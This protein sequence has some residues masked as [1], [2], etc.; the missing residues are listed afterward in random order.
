M[1]FV[2]ITS[3]LFSFFRIAN[4]EDRCGT[5]EHAHRRRHQVVADLVRALFDSCGVELPEAFSTKEGSLSFVDSALH[6]TSWEDD[7]RNPVRDK[8][9]AKTMVESSSRKL[10]SQQVYKKSKDQETTKLAQEALIHLRIS[11]LDCRSKDRKDQL[12]KIKRAVK[13]DLEA[14]INEK[15][16]RTT[17]MALYYEYVNKDT[18]D[19]MVRNGE[20]RNRETGELIPPDDKDWG[21]DNS[22]QPGETSNRLESTD[23]DDTP[24]EEQR[25]RL[26]ADDR[27]QRMPGRV[28]RAKTP[29]RLP[30]KRPSPPR[31]LGNSFSSAS[32]PLSHGDFMSPR[33]N[34]SKQGS[35]RQTKEQGKGKGKGKEKAK[36]VVDEDG[37]KT[38]TYSKG[39][40]R[41]RSA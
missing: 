11:D 20:I 23:E 31:S 7:I 21:W 15:D 13:E 5:L 39:T 33:G 8:L 32:V 10:S 6:L 26:D 19:S 16:G 4:S 24:F 12:E 36:E 28:L 1:R 40:G 22:V 35:S 18:F 17:R 3:I 37:F 14:V 41:K 25:G 30:S 2:R 27:Y 38:V 34:V 9:A 29:V